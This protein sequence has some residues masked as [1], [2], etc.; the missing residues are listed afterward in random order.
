MQRLG[1]NYPD[2]WVL[3]T[4]YGDVDEV[5]EAVGPCWRWEGSPSPSSW[6]LLIFSQRGLYCSFAHMHFKLQHVQR[7]KVYKSIHE[8]IQEIV[9]TWQHQIAGV[10][11]KSSILIFFSCP[12]RG[13]NQNTRQSSSGFGWNSTFHRAKTC[14]PVPILYAAHASA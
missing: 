5:S 2:G 3:C 9:S 8:S 10:L 1:S 13:K 14:G 7:M 4:R 6:Y 12:C 11:I